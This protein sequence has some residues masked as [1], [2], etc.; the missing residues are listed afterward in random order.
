MPVVPGSGTTV[1]DLIQETRR[2]LAGHNKLEYNRLDGALNDT[3][4]TLTLE[5]A[6]G[7]ITVGTYICINTEMMLVTSV[8]GLTVGVLRG[9]LGSFPET[10]DD[11]TL[12]E[13][14]PRWSSYVIK[15]ELKNEIRSWGSDL[16][17]PTTIEVSASS[18]TKQAIDLDI[19]TGFYHVLEVR[20]APTT[21]ET[22]WPRIRHFEVMRNA[23][24][25]TFSSGLAIQLL[26]EVKSGAVRVTYAA[27][28]DIGTFA[29]GLSLVTDVG[30]SESQ[31]DIPALG[32]AWRLLAI[33][34]AARTDLSPRHVS[35]RRDEVPPGHATSAAAALKQL[36]DHRLGEEA[37]RL[38]ARW[39]FRAG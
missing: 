14:N 34:E 24:T 21:G 33:D 35:G 1:A 36:R 25:D 38:R 20:R 39:P 6:A 29:D 15:E 11:N 16:F 17:A 13:V 7:G 4:E 10:H 32:A 19:D 9:M 37:A 18:K 8:T 22:T 26:E 27:H 31:L 30:M 3:T 28:F 12:I 2:H 5:W 23:D